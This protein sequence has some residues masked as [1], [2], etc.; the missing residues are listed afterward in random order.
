MLCVVFGIPG[1]GKTTVLNEVGKIADVK[2]INFG[3]VMFEEA[4]SRGL[5]GDRDKMRK[6]SK[7]VQ[8]D[9][10]QKAA[11]KIHN[12][13]GLGNIIVD[14]HAS[15][16]THEGY[17]PGLPEPV[18]R[19]LNPDALVLVECDS[20]EILGRRNKD[21]SR[22]RDAEALSEIDEHQSI[23]R[24]YSAVYS[25]LTN[26]TLLIVKNE[27]GK[28]KEAGERISLIFKK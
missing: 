1:V 18:L 22:Q 3:D 9:L 11:E 2:M 25:D 16:K 19:A 14:T 20:K 4:K 28:V 7:D 15:V 13:A 5:V 23:D 6:L 27:E 10:Q 26:C 24:A 8:S 21:Q 17:L 12:E